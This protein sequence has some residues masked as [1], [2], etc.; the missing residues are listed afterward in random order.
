MI[1]L[2]IV[3]LILLLYYVRSTHQLL[4]G[5][6]GI[7]MT[8]DM[9][10]ID[11]IILYVSKPN[12]LSSKMECYL[13]IEPEVCSQLCTIQIGYRLPRLDN[14]SF[15]ATITMKKQV[16]PANVD[17]SVDLLNGK[18]IVKHK[19]TIFLRLYKDNN[20]SELSKFI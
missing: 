8:E 17:I 6:T 9:P 15:S 3:L 4:T 14:H 18:L 11:T 5:L 13:I 19:D 16:I 1:V 20:L 2:F 10:D 12:G 7:W